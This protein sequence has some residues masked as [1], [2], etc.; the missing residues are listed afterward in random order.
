[1][2]PMQV[3]VPFWFGIWLC[4]AALIAGAVVLWA[5]LVLAALSI[6]LACIAWA[7]SWVRRLRA[8]KRARKLPITI[9]GEYTKHL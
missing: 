2:K 1:M 4:I 3:R 6:L 7:G 5:G 8:H 9:E